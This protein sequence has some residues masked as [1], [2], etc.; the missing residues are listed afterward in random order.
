MG[1]KQ[2]LK[3]AHLA[4]TTK[5]HVPMTAEQL[6]ALTMRDAVTTDLRQLAQLHVDTYNETHVGP[7]GSGPTVALRESQW[8][9]KLAEMHATSFVLV[10]ETP[11]KTLVGFC[12]VHPTNDNPRWAARLNKIY[13]RRPYQ[14]QGLGQAM[15]RE[16]VKRLVANGVASMALFT[17]VDNVPA[18]SFYEKLGGVRVHGDDGKFGGMYG[19]SDLRALLS[20]LNS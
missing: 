7:F 2:L 9:D 17:E 5:P 12:W 6:G 18:C 13:L 1:L 3:R 20:R 11:E 14:R 15:V 8:R 16:C 10:I 19:W 4:L